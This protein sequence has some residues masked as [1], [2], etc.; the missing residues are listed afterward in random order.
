MRFPKLMAVL[1][2]SGLLTACQD[3]AEATPV[4]R[5]WTELS[6]LCGQAYEGTVIEAPPGDTTFT[7]RALVM[8]V[9]SCTD[10]VIRIPFH[11]GEDRSRT[12]VLTRTTAGVRLKHD[13]RHAD[14]TEDAVT[15]YG[16]DSRLAEQDTLIE[17]PAD[18][19]TMAL[20]PAA[21]TNV[22][23]VG[24]DTKHFVYALRREGTDRRYRIEFDR[25]RPVPT[26][27]SPW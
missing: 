8:H 7:D 2:L 3:A 4:D 14:G 5:F 9:G 18:S 17:F 1:L 27:P 10:S 25:T 24:V 23:S 26:P 21:V 6:A 16:G 13:H 12:W 19:A 20:I 11:V 15:Q 22:W